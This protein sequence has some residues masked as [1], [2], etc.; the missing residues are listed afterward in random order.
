MIVT[1]NIDTDDANDLKVLRAMVP[2]LFPDTA[3]PARVASVY[4][5]ARRRSNGENVVF[6]ERPAPKKR[7]RKPKNK[8]QM[9]EA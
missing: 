8:E 4:E 3:K 2:A 6:E 7:G 9:E 5:S 1:F